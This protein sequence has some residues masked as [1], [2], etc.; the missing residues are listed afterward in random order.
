MVH[1]LHFRQIMSL[2]RISKVLTCKLFATTFT[3]K[4][5]SWFSQLSE[6]SIEGFEN[7]SI[8]FLEQYHSK[9]INGKPAY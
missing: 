5:F 8:K 3:R 2:E 1:L 4:A 9:E 6:G 7:F